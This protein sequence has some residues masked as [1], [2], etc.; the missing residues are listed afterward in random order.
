MGHLIPLAELAKLLVSK[1]GFTVTLMTSPSST[2]SK[3][4]QAFLSS[5]PSS[6]SPLY[7]PTVSLSD[8]LLS[9]APET[10][11][12]EEAV[13]LIPAI[14]SELKEL[15]TRH[16]VMGF[17]ADLF[18]AGTF[19]A[20]RDAGLRSY[21]FFPTNLLTLS[22]MLHLP[23]IDANLKCEFKELAEPVQL[24][25]CVPIPGSE[26]LLPL[27]DRS[28]ECYKWMV[29]HSKKYR[30]ADA[31]LVNS[32]DEIEPDAA[33]ILCQ[34]EPDRP[35][36]YLIGPLIQTGSTENKAGTAERIEESR[37]KKLK[38][39]KEKEKW[40]KE[41]Q[42]MQM[43]DRLEKAKRE[44]ERRNAARCMAEIEKQEADAA[45]WNEAAHMADNAG[46]SNQ[47][48]NENEEDE[49]WWDE[50]LQYVKSQ[51]L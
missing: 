40:R 34:P 24:P 33:K 42:D 36:V 35:P 41:I 2:A 18:R 43:R 28:N 51:D 30:E 47:H 44:E 50:I 10:R 27:Q 15:K 32:F 29:H 22:L 45:F 11:M 21:L 38:E 37:K 19:D 46:A 14:T 31:I 12:S 9:A 16:N 6:I 7:L 23:E 49:P 20:A 39:E 1:H 4:Q 48:D 3:T 25:G 5:L 17:V 8:L 13:R 26:I